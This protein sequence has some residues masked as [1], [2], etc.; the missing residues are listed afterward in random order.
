MMGREFMKW[1]TKLTRRWRG[2]RDPAA[3]AEAE[4]L[5]DEIE[6]RRESVQGPGS[7]W[8]TGG[9]HGR[10]SDYRDQ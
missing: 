5:R 7:P 4:R 1:L 8:G 3:H 10:E 9:T 2:S 6:M